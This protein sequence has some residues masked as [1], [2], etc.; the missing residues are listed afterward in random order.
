MPTFQFLHFRESVLE[1]AEEVEARDVLEAVEK[2][3]GKP[4]HLKVEVWSDHRRV[5]QIGP[6][7]IYPFLSKRR[8]PPNSD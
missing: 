7:P 3:A 5:A 1:R 4:P 8:T 2:A 6:S